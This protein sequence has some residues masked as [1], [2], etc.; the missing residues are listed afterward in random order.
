MGFSEPTYIQAKVI[1]PALEGKDV[2]GQAPTGS[3]KTVAFAVPIA[4]TVKRG[5]GVQALVVCPT[6]ELTL[7][8]AGVLK[9][10]TKYQGLT[11]SPIYG[12]V[13]L[14]PQREAL[15]QTEVV[16]GT[17]GRLLD[18]IHRGSLRLAGVRI[19]V[20]DEVDRMLD[21]GF[22]DDVRRI[23]TFTARD[24]QTMF[25]S[26]TIPGPVRRLAERFMRDPL[27]F[28]PI[29]EAEKPKVD[30][31]YIEVPEEHKFQLLLALIDY[32]NPPSAIIFCNTKIMADLLGQGLWRNGVNAAAIHGDL[33]QDRREKVM[34]EFRA[35]RLKILVATDVAS[36]GLDIYGISHIFN[37]DIPE[38]PTDYVHRIGRTARAGRTGKAISLLSPYSHD[39][40]RHLH[41]LH[42][43]IGPRTFEFD[44]EAYQGL[45]LSRVPRPRRDFHP[46]GGRG[47]GGPRRGGFGPRGRGPGPRRRR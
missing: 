37:Y 46:R 16:V 14:N 24:R 44:P 13:S 38:D 4:E 43:G 34:R 32:E 1:P 29:D 18:H 31:Y 3:G 12:G 36:R 39:A 9:D 33:T 15:R 47:G 35:G 30:E 42:P 45:D 25:F 22:I 21:M 20:L 26:A 10:V 17:P 7:Q 40:M 19:L 28:E 23:I 6:R 8:V 41:E 2:I 27:L 5:A 11:V